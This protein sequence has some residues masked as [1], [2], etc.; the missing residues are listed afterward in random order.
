MTDQQKD[1]K[2]NYERLLHA[3][4]V[5]QNWEWPGI[6]AHQPVDSEHSLRLVGGPVAKVKPRSVLNIHSL[7]TA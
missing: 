7:S 1:N 3:Q 6:I 4:L 5:I 2:D